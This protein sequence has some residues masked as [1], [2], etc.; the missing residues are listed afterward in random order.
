M[1]IYVAK[2]LG[3][4]ALVIFLVTLIVFVLLHALPGGPVVAIL[5]SRA[6]PEQIAQYTHELGYDRP[7]PVQYVKWLLSLLRG[8]LGDSFKLNDSVVSL[9]GNRLPKTVVL[10]AASTILAL[11]IG[12]PLGIL[13][14]VK[15]NSV[16]DHALTGITFIIYAVPSFFLGLILILGLAISVPVFPSSA[17]QSDDLS[18]VL[19]Q[20]QGLVLP[21]FTLA[22][23]SV[24]VFSR[25]MRSTV[26]ENLTQDYVRTVRAKGATEGRILL[27]HVLRN[28]L[29]PIVTLLGLALPTILAGAVV[30]EAIYNYPGMGLLFWQAAQSRDYPVLLGVTLL[31]G[32]ASVI[33][34]LLAD[35][36]YAVLDPRVRLKGQA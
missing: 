24:A 31:V 21:V 17:P 4:S 1:T 32:V 10:T 28:A 9:I 11:V 34:S 30:T 16:V 25:Y 33:G 12:L 35:L 14:A 23:L 22:L 7:L 18:T 2:R 13:Q 26:M 19:A 36:A 3:T 27:R 15:R 5:G 6:T 29:I 20:W 8:D